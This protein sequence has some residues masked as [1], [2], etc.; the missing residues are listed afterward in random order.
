MGC[1]AAFA[2]CLSHCCYDAVYGTVYHCGYGFIARAVGTDA[3]SAV[4]VVCPVIN[5]TVGLGTM[6]AAGGNAVISRK[7]ESDKNRRQRGLTA[8][9]YMAA[10]IGSSVILQ[11]ERWGSTGLYPALGASDLLFP[12]C[13]SLSGSTAFV[14][15]YLP[16]CC[17]RYFR[18]CLLL[19]KQTGTGIW[20]FCPAEARLANV[21]LDYIFIVLCGLGIRGAALGTGCGY[22]IL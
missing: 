8:G 17:K 15:A 2:F 9:D 14:Y 16:I 7:W 13:K 22:C 12:Y 4:N 10:V 6:L 20:P 18:I 11:W 19:L 1:G 3:L 21:I 5:I